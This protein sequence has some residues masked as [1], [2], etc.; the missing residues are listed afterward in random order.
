MTTCV[1]VVVPTYHRPAL[2]ERCLKA[3]LAQR[4]EASRYE[5]IVADDESS[6]QVAALVER[7]ACQTGKP[8]P[9]LRYLAVTGAHG[10]A[11]ARNTGWRHAAGPIIA[12][13]DDDCLPTAGWLRAGVAAMSDGAAGASGKLAIPCSER[14]TDYERN[15]ALLAHAEFVTANCFYRREA[16]EAVGGFDE[17][18]P[19]AWREDSDLAF[20]LVEQGARLVFAPAAVV[21][22]PIRPRSWGIS[23]SQQRKSMYN[24][25]LYR[26]HPQL[27]RERI[28]AAPPWRYYAIAAGLLIAVAGLCANCSSV[29]LAGATIW[30]ILTARFSLE[31]LSGTS[32]APAHLT[33]ML[34]TSALIPP[35]C[36]FWRLLG[37]IRYLAAFL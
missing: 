35:V 26:K 32:H 34:I 18:F 29:T 36:V 7:L 14:P 15:A 33:E 30:C 22:H 9:A 24:A 12:F 16:L 19:I 1:S 20:T 31:R 5:I 3:L 27:Y 37:A 6:P 8:A 21:I 28:Q 4:F 2:L 13:T 23:L 25:L 10:P 11:A 17:R